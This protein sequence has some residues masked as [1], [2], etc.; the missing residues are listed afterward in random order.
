MHLKTHASCLNL[1]YTGFCI[2]IITKK[3]HAY[4]IHYSFHA[5]K[6]Q[7]RC[8]LQTLYETVLPRYFSLLVTKRT[9]LYIFLSH[10][11]NMYAFESAVIKDTNQTILAIEKAL[12]KNV[13]VPWN[14]THYILSIDTYSAG[15][16]FVFSICDHPY[17]VQYT[18]YRNKYTV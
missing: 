10:K 16:F 12:L 7:K 15:T 11:S 6:S 8:I 9:N 1:R 2:V 5:K 3:N 14:L 13:H 18:H 4:T 17:T